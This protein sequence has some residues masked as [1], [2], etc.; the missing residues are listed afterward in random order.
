MP[1]TCS[2]CL[3][4]QVAELTG[5]SRRLVFNQVTGETRFEAPVIARR[6][7]LEL[8]GARSGATEPTLRRDLHV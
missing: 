4:P 3:A 2:S 1:T 6:L 7:C 8:T 5:R